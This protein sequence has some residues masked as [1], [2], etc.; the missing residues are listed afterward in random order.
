MNC[1]CSERPYEEASTQAPSSFLFRHKAYASAEMKLRARSTMVSRTSAGVRETRRTL[2]A[3][4]KSAIS[5]SSSPRRRC[6]G[7]RSESL[8]GIVGVRAISAC[9]K[10]GAEASVI[11]NPTP[12][13]WAGNIAVMPVVERGAAYDPVSFPVQ[14]PP[15]Q[16]DFTWQNAACPSIHCM[17]KALQVTFIHFRLAGCDIVQL[18][19]PH[20][21][22]QSVHQC[23]QI[24]GRTNPR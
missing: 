11:H 8:V 1:S 7:K 18:S 10:I 4:T 21:F 16:G 6:K 2:D 20:P 3:S 23:G 24:S 19:L 12:A 13:S 22:L 5:L 14:S 17:Q 15:G 9:L